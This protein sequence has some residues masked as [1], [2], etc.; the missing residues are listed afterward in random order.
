MKVCLF[1][2]SSGLRCVDHK[3]LI[4]FHFQDAN[5]LIKLMLD[6]KADPNLLCIGHSALS[7]VIGS[8]NDLVSCIADIMW[9]CMI[10]PKKYVQL[11]KFITEISRR[12]WEPKTNCLKTETGLTIFSSLFFSRIVC[13]DFSDCLVRTDSSV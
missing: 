9:I 3:S 6:Y 1:S 4:C 5:G 12:V 11:F 10:V 2:K 7:L 13:S 8:G